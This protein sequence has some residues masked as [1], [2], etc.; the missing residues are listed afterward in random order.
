MNLH[1]GLVNLRSITIVQQFFFL[2]KV[3]QQRLVPV[4][5]LI[6]N[7]RSSFLN[8]SNAVDRSHNT[9]N[10]S[11]HVH[12]FSPLEMVISAEK[13]DWN[14][15]NV[16]S[17]L[18]LL[19]LLPQE[20][21]KEKKEKDCSYSTSLSLLSRFFNLSFPLLTHLPRTFFSHLLLPF[22][23]SH[24][25]CTKKSFFWSYH[26]LLWRALFSVDSSF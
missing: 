2:K 7:Y 10:V 11:H 24:F 15:D 5:L 20:K 14:R 19:L 1:S 22:V 16:L 8:N 17:L 18:F 4:I 9:L 26:L 12:F 13:S 25:D 6:F 23:F 21:E 3:A